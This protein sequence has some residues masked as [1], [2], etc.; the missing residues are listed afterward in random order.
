MIYDTTFVTVYDTTDVYDTTF[1][2]VY[3]T[4]DVYDTTFITV[5]DTTYVSV[6]DTLFIDVTIT[7]VSP[8]NNINTIKVYPNPANDVVYIDNGNYM[9][10]SNYTIKIVNNIGQEIFNSNV[11]TQQFMIPVSTFGAEGLYFIQII[12]DNGTLLDTRKLV[13]N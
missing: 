7:G 2:T 3:D 11:N 10:M 6:T 4:T 5:Y 9:S 8:P 13:L 12:D 1:V